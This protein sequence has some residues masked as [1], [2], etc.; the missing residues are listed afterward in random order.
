MLNKRKN[1]VTT[2]SRS[3]KKM[4]LALPFITGLIAISLAPL[5][6]ADDS[7]LI[8]RA[9]TAK[10]SMT[11]LEAEN[12]VETVYAQLEKTALKACKSDKA[13]LL[14]LRQTVAGCV[15]DIMDQ[16]VEHASIDSLM[17]YHLSLKSNVN[18]EQLVFN[19]K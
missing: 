8:D 19:E 6:Q 10:F 11:E 18:T 16:F 14:Y 15:D 13:S 9:V 2:S 12:G 7:I 4:G 5:A 1:F 17:T 3:V